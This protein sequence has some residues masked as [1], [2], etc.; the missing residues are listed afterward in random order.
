MTKVNYALIALATFL[1][2]FGL[3]AK[4]YAYPHLAVMPATPQINS[5]AT[6]PEGQPATYFDLPT[7][8]EVT[9]PL[10]NRATIRGDLVAAEDA[11]SVSGQDVVVWTAYG[12]TGVGGEDCRENPFPLSGAIDKIALG[13]STSA[14]VPWPGAYQETGG[15]TSSS[16]INQGYVFKLPFGTQKATYPWWHAATN[17]A[18]PLLYRGTT[19]VQGLRVY[20][21]EQVIEPRKV[22]TIDLPGSVL[23]SSDA[24][25]TAD[26]MAG[27]R[28]EMTIEPETGVAI[29]RIVH[30]TSFLAIDGRKVLTLIDGT[31]VVDQ[32]TVDTT[33]A[34][35]KPLAL[36]LKALRL[37]VPLTFIP[38]GVLLLALV[39]IRSVRARARQ[40][41]SIGSGSV[42]SGEPEVVLVASPISA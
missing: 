32:A 27:T 22:G 37:W 8:K 30:P 6:T 41:T 31:F 29:T 5:V 24:T 23:G 35:Y 18:E 28:T 9:G 15:K 12:C 3:G 34:A 42:V 36:G 21:F 39:A 19:T 40:R 14:V 20:R 25:V 33:V 17:T 11:R 1:I 2:T 7:L 38:L 4:Y 16:P 26:R 10:E 13:T